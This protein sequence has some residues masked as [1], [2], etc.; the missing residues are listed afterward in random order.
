[1]AN[2]KILFVY[3]KVHNPIFE[4]Y[5]GDNSVIIRLFSNFVPFSK[6][7]TF[8][9]LA[10]V[11]PKNY[12]IEYIEGDLHS[13]NFDKKYD[14]VGITSTTAS[15]YLAYAIADEFRKRGVFVALG[16]YHVSALPDEAKQHAD[17][18][19]I[20]EAEETWPEFLKDFENGKPKP[21]YMIQR[22]IPVEKIPW[23]TKIDQNSGYVL[24][25]T[26]GCPNRCD[27]CSISNMKYRHNYRTRNINDVVEEIRNQANKSFAFY[28]DSLTVK[29]D[30]TKKLFKAIKDLDKRFIAYGNINVLGNDEKLLKLA[31]EAGCMTWMIGFESM[32]SSSLKSVGKITNNVDSYEKH[33]KKIHDYGMSVICFFVFGFDYDTLDVFD[34]TTEMIK[35]C[36]IDAPTSFVLTPLPGTPLF[37]RLENENRIIT[38]DWSKYN[39]GN[40]VFKPKQMSPE[41]LEYNAMRVHGDWYKKSNYFRR[42]IM[43]LGYGINP[44]IYSLTNNFFTKYPR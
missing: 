31:N 42:M 26:R 35:K 36:E 27:F 10:G 34:K 21:V 39:L 33:V 11:T 41:E 2:L 24:Q 29:P 32:S 4:K 17:V 25:A 7:M 16:G 6:S 40:A 30:Y 14:I 28:D 37:N 23:Q 9:T 1:M 19:F 20:G 38:H 15:I 43:M 8:S 22:P 3:P 13:I 5:D 12:E 44:L 18:I